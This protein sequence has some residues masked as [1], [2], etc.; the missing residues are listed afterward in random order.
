MRRRLLVASALLSLPLAIAVAIAAPLTFQPV[1]GKIVNVVTQV[2]SQNHYR[3]QVID[4]RLSAAWLNNYVE[5]L[6]PE[7]LFLLQADIDEFRRFENTLDEA[8]ERIP[9]DLGPAQAIHRRFVQRVGERTAAVEAILA[10]PDALPRTGVVDLDREDA[11][12]ATSSA[13]LDE[14]WRL[15]LAEQVGRAELDGEDRAKTVG[16]LLTRYARMRKDVEQQDQG[17]ILE[18][19]LGAFGATYDPHS[20]WFKPATKE[21]FDISMR[22]SLQGIGATLRTDGEHTK[23]VSLVP[24]GPAARS[25][26]LQ[27][28][29]RIVA[30]AQGSGEAEDIVGLRIDKVVKLIRGAKGTDVVLTIIPANATDPSVTKAVRITRDEVVIADAAA[31]GS[32]REINGVKVGVIDVPSFY[33]DMRRDPRAPNS[34][35]TTSDVRRILGE[36][37]AQGVKVV[38][39]DLRE[40]GGG[41]LTQAIDLTG[42]FIDKGPVVQIKD[43]DARVQVMEDEAPGVAWGGP[44]VVLTS[45]HS[46]SASEIFAGAIQDYRRGLIVGAP[47]THGKGSVQEL[48]DLAPVLSRALGDP[49]AAS[50]GALKYTTSLFYRV[51]GRSTQAVG[52]LADVVIPSPSD[53]L[54]YREADLDN[55]LPYDEIRSARFAPLAVNLPVDRLRQRSGARVAQDP[56]FQLMNEMRALRDAQ[57]GKPTPL[58]EAARK[59]ELATWEALSARAKALGID[60]GQKDPVLDEALMIAHDL[61]TG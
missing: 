25:G 34:R 33:Q 24:G 45:V 47:A 6:D 43:R 59:A 41:A 27:P 57:D 46:A 1:D 19:W 29:D 53:N 5:A 42:L 17:D 12:W 30:V 32:V 52:V 16:R 54:P 50:A 9:A 13:A 55:P 20:V 22:D 61:F 44:L 10:K 28:E 60:E 26:L 21:D 49:N 23:V 18:L 37:S 7:R 31:K 3:E 39:V 15:R 48:L 56:S 51:S 58:D 11:P 35:N 36:L 14:L 8:V 40:N 2:L 4:D 38:V